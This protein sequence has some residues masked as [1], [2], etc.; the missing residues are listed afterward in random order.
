MK[1]G[2]KPSRRLA[3]EVLRSSS[4]DTEE[5]TNKIRK[6]SENR[7]SESDVKNIP[8]LKPKEKKFKGRTHTS[9]RDPLTNLTKLTKKITPNEKFVNFC[10]NLEIR[11]NQ[12][13]ILHPSFPNLKEFHKPGFF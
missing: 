1:A 5:L 8:K 12:S 4:E 13:S 9:P 10:L 2:V 6:L 3:E 11:F 7:P